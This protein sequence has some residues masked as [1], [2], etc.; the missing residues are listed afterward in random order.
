MNEN[1]KREVQRI[2]AALNTWATGVLGGKKTKRR[3]RL[4]LAAAWLEAQRAQLRMK[5]FGHY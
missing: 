2:N 3:R 1:D 5:R 4:S